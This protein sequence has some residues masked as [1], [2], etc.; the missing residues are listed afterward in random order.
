MQNY[1]SSLYEMISSFW[2]NRHLIMTLVEREVL[3][4]YRGSIFGVLWSFF[5]PALLLFI[6]TYVFSIIFK[7]RWA[8]A[9]DSKITFAL[10]LFAGMIPFN[11]FS[12]CFTRAPGLILSNVN[13]VKK[14]VFPLEILPWVI[15]GS[16]LFHALI[17]FGVWLVAYTLF[18]GF[19]GPTV[20][21][22]P[23]VLI[24]LIFTTMGICW[25]IA[26]LGVFLRD[27]GQFI[28]LAV[29]ALMFLSPVFYPIS[30]LPP[31]FRFYA[32]LNPLSFPI[33]Q[34]RQVLFW[35]QLPNTSY[36][37]AYSIFSIAIAF[38]GFS[39]FQK[40]RKGFADVL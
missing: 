6:Y 34:S 33:E 19:P 18:F 17:T 4:K 9:E 39:W 23:I 8:D 10:V 30:S 20:I 27:I 25:G 12:E 15:M 22:F 29:T 7:A 38:L 11:L 37:I 13:Y 28:N 5:N 36:L 3:G 2:R 40:T 26:A 24:P 35:G 14:V 16:A 32:Y 1:S 21:F 31:K